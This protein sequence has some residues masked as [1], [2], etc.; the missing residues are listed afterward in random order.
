MF[1][2]NILFRG[3]IDD[4]EDIKFV[5]HK[6]IAI[7]WGPLFKSFWLGIAP[8]FLLFYLM[9]PLIL[10]WLG[11]LA[12]GVIV[13]IYKLCDWYFDVWLITDKGVLDIEWN[14]IFHRTSTKIEYHTI[15]G[16][17][18]EIKGFWGT[19]FGYG[20]IVLDKIGDTT[21]FS[22]ENAHRP[23]LIELNILRNQEEFLKHKS[24]KDHEA[25]KGMLAEMLQTHNK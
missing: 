23:K 7:F 20:T 19:L 1:L 10:L 22:M 13:F 12:I 18:F 21:K 5:A 25:L 24:Y 14:G 16:V 9:P 6:H 17:T 11:W 2:A 3:H 8:P 15:N 4:E